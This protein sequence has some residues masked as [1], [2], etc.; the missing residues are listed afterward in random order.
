MAR[1][2]KGEFIK[3]NFITCECGYNNYKQA[4]DTYG[5]CCRC[6]KVLNARAYFRYQLKKA[7]RSSR[8]KV[9]LNYELANY[10]DSI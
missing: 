5:T 4:I 8:R 7:T 10:S 2:E 3:E 6:K 1:M 9:W